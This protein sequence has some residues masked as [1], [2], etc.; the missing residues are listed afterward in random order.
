[1][2]KIPGSWGL[3]LFYLAILFGVVF[4]QMEEE[5]PV[6]F[7]LANHDHNPRLVKPFSERP[8]TLVLISSDSLWNTHFV[9]PNLA[10]RSSVDRINID[11]IPGLIDGTI[12]LQRMHQNTPV[13]MPAIMSMDWYRRQA[14][15]EEM[16]SLFQTHFI[17]KL[18]DTRTQRKQQDSNASLRL[19]QMDL[20]K[21][22]V[23]LNIKGRIDI[24]GSVIFQDEEQTQLSE[25]ESK[26]WDL[27]VNQRQQFDIT[28]TIGDRL[29]ILVNQNSEADFAWENNMI[30][31]YTGR[32]DDIFQSAEAGNI[33]LRL[34]GTQFV[35]GGS[36]KAEGL[37]GI[38]MVHQLGPAKV[39][40]IVSREQSKQSNRSFT[41]G[42][43]S[44][45]YSKKDWDFVVD[46][47]FFIEDFFKDQFYPLDPQLNHYYNPEYVIG[48]YRV[49]KSNSTAIISG[50][51]CL[52][53][54]DTLSF[55]LD[56]QWVELTRDHD[57]IINQ[58]L[59]W[60]RINTS[61]GTSEAL[62]IAYTIVNSNGE[63]IKAV[64]DVNF[65]ISGDV[66]EA[67]EPVLVEDLSGNIIYDENAGGWFDDVDGDGY[68]GET[69]VLASYPDALYDA[70]NGYIYLDT[71]ENGIW[72][73]G[74][75]GAENNIELRLLRERKPSTPDSK[76]WPLMFKNVY[77]LGSMN[78]QEEGLEVTIVNVDGT[79]GDE[80]DAPSGRP[81][82]NVFGLDT[83]ENETGANNT[84]GD[85]KV[86]IHGS[87]IDLGRGELFLPALMPFGYNNAPYDSI[88]AGNGWIYRYWGTSSI[89]VSNDLELLE[90]IDNDQS[91]DEGPAMYF[92]SDTNDRTAEHRFVIK[93]KSSERSSSVNL[94]GFMIVEGSEE[95]RLNGRLLQKGSQYNIDYFTGNVN[96]IDCP[97]CTDPTSDLKI[98]FQENEIISFDQKVLAGTSVELDLNDNLSFGAVAMYYNQ[99]IV[100]EKVEIGYEPVRNFIWDVNGE[101]KAN[102]V[103][104]LTN[105]VN[106]LPFVQ[107]NKPSSFS[108][109]GE[110]AQVIPDPNP[111]GE[112]YLD[113]FESSKRTTT[114][115]IMQ[116]FW[117]KS[118]PPVDKDIYNRGE[119]I[120]YN[121]YYD[122]FTTDIWPNMETSQ[123]AN[124]QTTRIL[125]LESFF[126]DET[127]GSET[128]GGVTTSL[129]ASEYNQ[130]NNKYM[131]I[132]VSTE[133]VEDENL[134]LHI[135]IGHISED[136]NQNGLLDTED[137]PFNNMSIGNGYLEEGEDVG[138]DACTD[139]YEDGW[140]GCL[141][142]EYDDTFGSC[143]DL[144][145]MTYAEAP[146]SMKNTNPWVDPADPNNDNWSG[147]PEL[148]DYRHINGTEN[149]HSMAGFGYPDSEDLNGN[150]AKDFLNDYFTY[151]IY[152]LLDEP[153][154][155]GGTNNAGE[156]WKLYRILLPDFVKTGDGTVEWSDVQNVRLWIDG[157]TPDSETGYTGRVL[158]AKM[159]L[160]GN[161]WQEKG[162]AEIGSTAWDDSTLF[163]VAVANTDENS[164][165]EP[166]P[167]VKGEYDEVNQV[168]TREQSLVLDFSEG[169]GIETGGIP[170]HSEATVVKYLD[171]PNDKAQSFFAYKKM[172][173][174]V[175][176]R[177]DTTNIRPDW[178]NA[179]TAYTQL[180]FQFGRDDNF[181]EIV[182][183][184]YSGWDERN[185]LDIDLAELTRFKLNITALDDWIPSNHD[186]GMDSVFSL[187]ETGCVDSYGMGS[188]LPG[189]FTY[190]A[191]LDSLG[192]VDTD[193][194]QETWS[195]SLTICGD[196]Y[197]QEMVQGYPRCASC[198]PD[199]PN[200]DD[201]HAG[202]ST[203]Q[204]DP[205][206]P[207]DI[208][209][210]SFDEP[211]VNIDRDL[212]TEGNGRRDHWDD[213]ANGLHDEGEWIEPF[214]D[215]NGNELFDPPP[216]GYDETLGVW[217][218][219]L[220][221][222]NTWEKVRV[223]GEPAINRIDQI[224]VGV[225]N[226]SDERMYGEVF[227]DELRMTNVN[228]Q[229]GRAMRLQGSI[230][231]ADLLDISADFQNQD[232]DF[233]SL[234]ERLGMGDNTR[235]ITLSTKLKPDLFL[236]NS[237]GV[238]VPLN[239]TYTSNVSSPKY[240][241]GTDILAGSFSET[242]DS[243]KSI[244]NK[245]SVS[246]SF[247]KTS[248][249]DNWFTRYTLDRFAITTI[250][251]VRTFK[252]SVLVE[253][254]EINNY[255]I[256]GGYDLTF[257]SD[258]Y[259]QVL[260][261]AEKIPMV[262]SSLAETR[263]YYSPKSFG[264]N[265]NL[266]ESN[267][268]KLNRNGTETETP[269]LKMT[270][271]FD[272]NYQVT[273]SLSTKYSKDINS[274][275]ISYYDDK[276]LA[277]KNMSPGMITNV[278]ESLN[279]TY[280]PDFLR[281]LK[282][283]V[284]YNFNY[285]WK[286]TSQVDT[287]KSATM[288]SDGALN[289]TANLNP[290][291]MIETIYQPKNKPGSSRTP[292]SN[293]RR[294]QS[295]SQ[296]KKS[297][298]Q[299]ENP[300]L[301][302]ILDPLHVVFSRISPI[303]F[304]YKTTYRNEHSNL[305]GTPGFNFK[306]GWIKN[307]DLP[308]YQGGSSPHSAVYKN[309]EDWSIKTGVALTS[310][311]NVN[312]T[313][314]NN[315]TKSLDQLNNKETVSRKQTYL[316][317][318]DRG[319]EGMP[320]FGWSVNVSRLERLPFVNK[321]FKTVSLSHNYSGDQTRTLHEGELNNDDYTFNFS[322]LVGINM[323]TKGKVPLD[324]SV[325]YKRNLS[326]NNS[327]VGQTD[328]SLQSSISAS[329]KYNH[330]GGL[331][332]PVF[333]F[334]D[335]EITNDT[336]FTMTVSYDKTVPSTLMPGE[337][338]FKEN[339][340]KTNLSIR[341]EIDY[342]FTRYV[343]GGMHF[344]YALHDDSKGTGSRTEKDIGFKVTIKI[345]G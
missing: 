200:G 90:D 68:T 240:R 256:A 179:D 94:G 82:L 76:T 181:Y 30:L 35:S 104:M 187:Y 91:P 205:L 63:V 60:I 168:W 121:P 49:Y 145:A 162:V 208:W 125:I 317:L 21:V 56:D 126:A 207:Q 7:P 175:F 133:Q 128:W 202:G 41:G 306:V 233:H 278:K 242:P 62:G 332:I 227:V 6:T 61:L 32:D 316:P 124:N 234:R 53:P 5:V 244:T 88:P 151:T 71:N 117:K 248:R 110:Y 25:R 344:Q 43:A 225:R 310:Q 132:W 327:S 299:I 231:F 29:E 106:T 155:E 103:D 342:T 39:T 237:W 184:I 194:Y 255:K 119:L 196:Q 129:Y 232:A 251:A 239:A 333:F 136:I 28:G 308:E 137:R 37:F 96:F 19:V 324:L 59:G 345:Q 80:P 282:P 188:G 330:K 169:D 167:G 246:S 267:N 226:T 66:G 79:L 54:G 73:M 293:R 260:K 296:S 304:S 243:V 209:Q 144:G 93:V 329:A 36:S 149:N 102:N 12:I 199:D 216:A 16:H 192:F 307:P 138:M 314:T 206:S 288:S 303:N 292:T 3:P 197:W 241:S 147:N 11:I 81:Y 99:S 9:D 250:S 157:I 154:S 109:N 269:S 107:T 273:K 24:D 182:R 305:E 262:G 159:E 210:G 185:H 321:I 64:G 219:H 214:N 139:E 69:L 161:E 338:E 50:T 140:G 291:N 328:R 152:P 148:G 46:K 271:G 193:F 118:A 238:K 221:R 75:A 270:R 113:D 120:W 195:D 259:W 331:N 211:L 230:K 212:G 13:G 98:T 20:G 31:R 261:F 336:R 302:A 258:N 156:K 285:N 48:E 343:T 301:V 265:M 116:R 130:K 228:R 165:Y 341:P 51:A 57:Y 252:S 280:S 85:G 235:N 92:S 166:P 163:T 334:R 38:K 295:G 213:N 229:N 253:K 201:F 83:R 34:P 311:L 257:G 171:I 23:A 42:E 286:R 190:M 78:I 177:P 339:S 122:V 74:I 141:C 281:W 326:I 315:F 22:P 284:T 4:A 65:E 191:I 189:N 15:R 320:F 17:K 8:R 72:D 2:K 14:M 289:F 174:Y 176:G 222:G 143:L 275:L 142:D 335:F 18:T 170:G 298:I 279:N 95:I 164:D 290:R 274:N 236:P 127:T 108:I 70:A 153:V 1:M 100:D 131:D 268:Y 112:A 223:K 186:T 158:I 146:E 58:Q 45:E 245:I 283:K 115:S 89:D 276:L 47:Y 160:V 319:D 309:S 77:S 101:Y 217:E 52:D 150:N 183:P 114:P 26:S 215:A 312:L 198:T 247:K 220:D 254:E 249:S 340:V 297:S 87:L 313:Y 204:L 287:V 203:S 40:S 300:I 55:C 135:D 10:S 218:W 224:I 277:L 86:D 272:L 84:D 322:P 111:L 180:V 323:K 337:D 294:G 67:A 105:M 33:G 263:L 325:N 97:E 172:E 27:D 44:E 123:R 266:E 264:A 134:A 318:G 178:Y 173:M